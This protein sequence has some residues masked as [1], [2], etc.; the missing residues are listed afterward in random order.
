TLYCPTGIISTFLSP[1]SCN[2]LTIFFLRSVLRLRR[3]SFSICDLF[4]A[5]SLSIPGFIFAILR[6]LDTVHINFITILLSHN[7]FRLK[8]YIISIKNFKC[9]FMI[10]YLASFASIPEN[11]I[12]SVELSLF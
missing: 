2:L 6:L 4:T 3:P 12:N 8:T 11:R 10:N 5:S 1:F 7:R 9:F